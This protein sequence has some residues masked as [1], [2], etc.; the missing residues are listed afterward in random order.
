MWSCCVELWRS[1]AESRPGRVPRLGR[2][3]VATA[4]A[5]AGGGALSVVGHECRPMSM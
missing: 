3:G 5:M 2:K 1:G 4:A